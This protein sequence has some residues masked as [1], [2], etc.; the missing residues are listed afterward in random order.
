MEPST[1]F[2]ELVERR[3]S[4]AEH[5]VE[6]QTARRLVQCPESF[7]IIGIQLKQLPEKPL[8]YLGGCQIHP[9]QS[10]KQRQQIESCSFQSRTK[11]QRDLGG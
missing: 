2:R 7:H 9:V 1:G 10:T 11:I 3:Q 4:V 5:G 6:I 8:G